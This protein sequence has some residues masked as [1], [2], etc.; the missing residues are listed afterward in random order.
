MRTRTGTRCT[1]F[2][3]LPEEFSAGRSENCWSV[4]GAMLCTMPSQMRP[5]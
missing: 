5:G 2:T 3:Q 1:T 4:A